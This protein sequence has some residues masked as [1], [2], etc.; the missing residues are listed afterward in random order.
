MKRVRLLVE[1]DVAPILRE[2]DVATRVR[3]IL[4]E[5]WQPQNKH[6]PRVLVATTKVMMAEQL[7]LEFD[8][9]NNQ[10]LGQRQSAG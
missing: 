3:D 9:E 6:P 10:G 4:H 5:H 7:L 8:D 2:K 1:M